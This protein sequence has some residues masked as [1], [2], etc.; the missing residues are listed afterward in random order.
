[1]IRVNL[2]PEE[3]RRIERAPLPL[4][5]LIIVG[6]AVLCLAI[7]FCVYLSLSVK[8]KGSELKRT[9]A[10]RMVAEERAKW[11]DRLQAELDSELRRLN[12]IMSIRV[13]RIYWSKKLDLLAK[14]APS[15]IW[16]ASVKMEQK[17]PYPAS[18]KPETIKDGGYL[19]LQGYQRLFDLGKYGL[20]REAL[21]KNRIFYSDFASMGMPTVMKSYWDEAIEEDRVV[22]QFN[23]ILSLKPQMELQQ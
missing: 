2:L 14:I 11:A 18:A 15:D 12:T 10:E 1:M 23:M 4:L 17:D 6:I 20:F 5:L 3:Y 16:F 19:Q 8:T 7:S 13:S 9:I 21:R 22:L